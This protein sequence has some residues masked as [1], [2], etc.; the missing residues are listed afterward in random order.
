MC[1]WPDRQELDKKWNLALVNYRPSWHLC[2]S[3]RLLN[4]VTEL[5]G[6]LPANGI[7]KMGTGKETDWSWS[8]YKLENYFGESN[9]SLYYTKI[10]QKNSSSI[11]C[12]WYLI[13]KNISKLLLTSQATTLKRQLST[14]IT[15]VQICRR[16]LVKKNPILC[17]QECAFVDMCGSQSACASWDSVCSSF[18]LLNTVASPFQL[19]HSDRSFFCLI[20]LLSGITHFLD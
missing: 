9:E 17:G 19:M 4:E 2:P 15:V 16:L 11:K 3:L 12:S 1:A 10:I 5:Q 7:V 20:P 8:L 18:W 14:V 13:K 6:H